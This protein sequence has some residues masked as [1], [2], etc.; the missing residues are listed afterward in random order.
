MAE[1]MTG[2]AQAVVN[3]LLNQISEGGAGK[4]W[5]IKEHRSQRTLTQNAYYWVLLTKLADKLEVS[6]P[7]LHNRMLRDYGQPA[8]VDRKLVYT[9][10]PDTDEAEAQ[11][12]AQEKYH[13]RPTSAIML[14]NKGEPLR[15]YMLLRGSSD[16]DVDE[17]SILVDGL[18]HE[19]EQ[20]R[21]EVLTPRELEMMRDNE[22]KHSTKRS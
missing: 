15:A 6:K 14:N 11:I 7:E 1:K 13:L 12:L 21:I 9:Y 2:T 10:L 18:V 22:R 19:A 4:L 17:M 5:E 20:H 8:I 3:F 16:Y